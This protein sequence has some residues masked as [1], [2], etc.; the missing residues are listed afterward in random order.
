MINRMTASTATDP[1]LE[2]LYERLDTA[3]QLLAA[4]YSSFQERAGIVQRL[5]SGEITTQQARDEDRGE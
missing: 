1:G 2:E 3:A 5:C 4:G